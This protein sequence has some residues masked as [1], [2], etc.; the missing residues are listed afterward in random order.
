MRWWVAALGVALVGCAVTEEEYVERY[1]ELACTHYV[2]CYPD[3]LP[4]ESVDACID[5]TAGGLTEVAVDPDCTYDDE[6]AAECLAELRQARC[7]EAPQIFEPC[8]GV[9]T[10]T[11]PG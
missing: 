9:F 3:L 10:C 5:Q 11:T 7:E 1:A 4:Y 2:E 6:Q 8:T